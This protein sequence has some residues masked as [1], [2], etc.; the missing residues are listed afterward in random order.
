[1]LEISF[2]KGDFFIDLL[3]ELGV[4]M[5]FLMYAVAYNWMCHSGCRWH[6]DKN[7]S[8]FK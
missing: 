4:L 8:V 7:Y 6:M 2:V 1:M 3:V 5:K